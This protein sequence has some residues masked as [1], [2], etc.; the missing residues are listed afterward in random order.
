MKLA[1][2]EKFIPAAGEIIIARIDE[3]RG[4]GIRRAKI[5]PFRHI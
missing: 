5:K 1:I 4:A 2:M 3:K